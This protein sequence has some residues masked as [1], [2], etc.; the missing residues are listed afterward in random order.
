[1]KDT[2]IKIKQPKIFKNKNKN[3]FENGR[4]PHFFLMEDYLNLFENGNDLEKK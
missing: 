2:S 3:I 1:M 4:Q